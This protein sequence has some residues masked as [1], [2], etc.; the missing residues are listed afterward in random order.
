MALIAREF[1]GQAGRGRVK[2]IGIT[3]TNGKTTTTYMVKS[4]LEHAGVKT[5]LI[6]TIVDMIGQEVLPTE[7]TTPESPDLFALL[8]RMADEDCAAVVMEVSSHSL[9]LGPVRR[10]LRIRGGRVSRT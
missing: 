8:A 2:L 10:A 4:V 5:G 7:R 9:A 6:G 1:Y 3:G